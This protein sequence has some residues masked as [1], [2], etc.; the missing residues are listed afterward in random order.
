MKYEL[1]NF[2]D[3][4]YEFNILI[5]HL[6]VALNYIKMKCKINA[7]DLIVLDQKDVKYQIG[8]DD[9]SQRQ[10]LEGVSK[11]SPR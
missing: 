11:N 1:C 2:T 3:S 9:L 7:K 4:T 5:F 10:T 8:R 6:K